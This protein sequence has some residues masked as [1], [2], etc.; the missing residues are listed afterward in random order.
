MLKRTL[1][2]QQ[3]FVAAAISG[4]FCKELTLGIMAEYSRS[5]L[6]FPKLS[7]NQCTPLFEF[8]KKVP[9]IKNLIILGP[10]KCK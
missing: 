5:A 3:V 8:H 9:E 4:M 6:N 1:S 10:W 2:K 7:L